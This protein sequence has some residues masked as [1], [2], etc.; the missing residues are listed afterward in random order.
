MP[1]VAWFNQNPSALE[2]GDLSSPETSLGQKSR[3]FYLYIRKVQDSKIAPF[4][5]LTS[6][7]QTPNFPKPQ[8]IGQK[9]VFEPSHIPKSPPHMKRIKYF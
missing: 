9:R 6:K 5:R 4:P 3:P 8:F 2:F 1:Q 7:S